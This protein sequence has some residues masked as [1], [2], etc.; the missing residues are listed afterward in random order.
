MAGGICAVAAEDAAGAPPPTPSS[1]AAEARIAV[2]MHGYGQP[3]RQ[4]DCEE[5]LHGI[6]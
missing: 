1:E 4:P 2:P 3:D 6:P 5:A